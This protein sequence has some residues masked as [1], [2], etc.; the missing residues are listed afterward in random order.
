[1]VK[2]ASHRAAMASTRGETLRDGVRL[3]RTV[4]RYTDSHRCSLTKGGEMTT[5]KTDASKAGKILA[6]PKS[7]KDAKS[8]AGSDLSQAKGGKKK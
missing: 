6:N 4:V 1:M 5:S 8:V 3:K 7:S 2:T